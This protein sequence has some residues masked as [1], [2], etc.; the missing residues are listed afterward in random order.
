MRCPQTQ[1]LQ[2]RTPPKSQTAATFLYTRLHGTN[3]RWMEILSLIADVL[4][5]I[6][7]GEPIGI[8]I[9]GEAI[10]LDDALGNSDSL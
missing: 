10:F 8:H 9:C 6:K 1:E 3:N 5:N 7:K 4:I 2:L